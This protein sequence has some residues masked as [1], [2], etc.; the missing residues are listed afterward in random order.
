MTDP[1]D[2]NSPAILNAFLKLY[3]EDQEQGEVRP[4]T[5]YQERFAGYE[6]QIAER[7]ESLQGSGETSAF[8]AATLDIPSPEDD[9]TIAAPAPASSPGQQGEDGA[10][11]ETATADATAQQPLRIGPYRLM[12][13]L[14][15]GGM[16][17]VYLA[18]QTEP[19]KRQVA[20][21]LVRSAMTSE[22]FLVRFEAERQAIALMNHINI[23]KIFD[24][25]STPDG[26]PYFAME[27]APGVPLKSYC[28]REKLGLHQRLD[29]FLQVCSGVRHA[30]QKGIIHRDLKPSN[31]LVGND[32]EKP[33]VKIID[34]GVA[35]SM[36]Q[37]LTDKPLETEA[38]Q[39]V[40]TPEYM[41]P[42]Q[43]EMGPAGID[44]RTDVYALGVILYELLCG[45]LPF[46]S[47]T[48][49]GGGYTEMK[50]LICEVDPP[51]PSRRLGE[52]SEK[53]EL[54]VAFGLTPASLERRLQG[55]LDW[56]T[57]KAIDKDRSRRYQSAGEL[58]EDI[59]RHLVHDPVLAGPPTLG[60]KLK[61]FSRKHRAGIFSIAALLLISTVITVLTWQAGV[62]K[63][64][65][66]RV[67]RSADKI[68]QA[69][70]HQENY[71]ALSRKLQNDAD[72][73]EL[74]NSRHQ[75]WFPA[76]H[77]GTI[78]LFES[79]R[80]LNNTRSHLDTEFAA[81]LRQLF[82]AEQEAPADEKT[83]L[84][85]IKKNTE[86]IYANRGRQGLR[87][88]DKLMPADSFIEEPPKNQYLSITLRSEPPGAKVHLYRYVEHE[89][90]LLPL[91]YHP[92]RDETVPDEQLIDR[93]ALEFEAIHDP[94]LYATQFQAGKNRF[95]PG[96][97]FLAV[98]GRPVRSR[99]ELAIELG[100]LAPGKSITVQ[101]IRSGRKRSVTW[102][103]FPAA[104]PAM[105]EDLLPQVA[106]EIK[107][108]K[109][110]N[111][112]HQL[113]FTFT[114][115][116]LSPG[117]DNLLGT[118]PIEKGSSIKL[119]KGSYLAV[120]ELEGRSPVKIPIVVPGSRAEIA[121]R[122][123]E[124]LPA[125]FVYIAAGSFF[126]G[127]DDQSQARQNLEPFW[128]SLPGFFISRLEVSFGD[129]LRFLNSPEVLARTDKEGTVEPLADWSELTRQGLVGNKS[130]VLLIPYYNRQ[131]LFA[132]AG[133]DSWGRR[134]EV[135][136]S[137]PLC[138]ISMLAALEYAHWYT[139]N[140]DDGFS[141]RLPTDLEWE[142]TARGV[143]GRTHVWGEQPVG[144]FCRSE[145]SRLRGFLFPESRGVFP[146]DESI[147]GIRDLAGSVLEPTTSRTTGGY[148]SFRGGW[149]GTADDYLFHASTRFGRPAS[150]A[151][152]DAG[153]R[154]VAV[155]VKK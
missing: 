59:Q 130:R 139:R 88:R 42:E 131:E 141:Y 126:A 73:W 84:G 68:E 32:G 21:K 7:Y 41:S 5:E 45:L 155:R 65:L 82:E 108:G 133:S 79:R 30:H 127:G 28:E 13:P 104:G 140:R 116:P 10:T 35:R 9:D 71:L 16:G 48:L 25:G 106:A 34:F 90:H 56:I 110:L 136:A 69:K 113:G 51:E 53:G 60:Y 8:K 91:P 105:P 114:G 22:E 63:T 97:R 17:I 94:E 40:G 124:K 23:A 70:R 102:T 120:M 154:L 145:K 96:D 55:D 138:G 103:P 14:G 146:N 122:I 15:E 87:Q 67:E 57:M 43:A 11:E 107:P 81:A 149:Y 152:H 76:W 64:R 142:K 151:Q 24:A 72:A 4:L 83:L 123:P 2:K 93:A 148:V 33:V 61:K 3:L 150:K 119:P 147:Y 98:G 99:T 19:I 49:R 128:Y 121:V 101:V 143:D 129:Y 80:D 52:F 50:W 89:L 27:Y 115:L 132:R 112:H 37:H 86:E 109:L 54:C 18:T 135:P 95:A 36:D 77:P 20:L 6:N 118:T 26:K 46:D 85:R 134:R 12:K 31:I 39:M 47:E 78:T 44:T 125:G 75:G 74:Q 62:R 1:G 100:K 137:G 38:G 66:Q 117:P 92:E 29:L 153:I 111:I 144:S 58:A